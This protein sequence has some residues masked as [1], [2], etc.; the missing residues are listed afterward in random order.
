M[1][2]HD[3]I[4]NLDGKHIKTS[5]NSGCALSETILGKDRMKTN[6]PAMRKAGDVKQVYMAAAG[7]VTGKS[8]AA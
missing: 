8:Q 1:S 6:C 4:A 2:D 7:N 3:V 5:S